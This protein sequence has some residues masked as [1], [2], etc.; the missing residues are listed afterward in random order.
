[1]PT[2]HIMD[3]LWGAARASMGL[4]CTMP[5]RR[6]ECK[7]TSPSV[8]RLT[9]LCFRPDLPAGQHAGT[10]GMLT[11]LPPPCRRAPPETHLCGKQ[12]SGGDLDAVVG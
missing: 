12:N 1:M 5:P 7:P 8:E 4:A 11:A 3:G 6:L 9:Q 2:S 10:H